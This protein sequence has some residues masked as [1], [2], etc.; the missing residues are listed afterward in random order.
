M[1][2]AALSG[3]LRDVEGSSP[4]VELEITAALWHWS[5]RAALSA[6]PDVTSDLSYSAT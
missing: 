1:K 6:L 4:E 5:G 2:E 3:L